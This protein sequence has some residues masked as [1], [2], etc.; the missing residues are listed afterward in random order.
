[1][2]FIFAKKNYWERERGE[3]LGRGKGEAGN[4]NRDD[5]YF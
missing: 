4:E 2:I 1:M 3:G 5:L